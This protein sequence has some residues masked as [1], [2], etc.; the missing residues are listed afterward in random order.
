MLLLHKSLLLQPLFDTSLSVGFPN[1]VSFI[2][3]LGFHIWSRPLSL[4]LNLGFQFIIFE[5][6]L[7]FLRRAL[8]LAYSHFNFAASFLMSFIFVYS[9]ILVFRFLSLRV[10]FTIYLCVTASLSMLRLVNA[11][12]WL[13]KSK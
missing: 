10:K 8:C 3:I 11:H 13:Q 12:V 4:L 1:F 9:L 6:H 7:S 2:S 5:F